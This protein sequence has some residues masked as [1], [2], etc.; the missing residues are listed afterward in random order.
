MDKVD[1]VTREILDW[2]KEQKDLPDDKKLLS[3][4]IAFMFAE[5]AANT[6]QLE[7]ITEV[8]RNVLKGLKT[9]E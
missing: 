5:A 2:L 9:D 6:E 1:E 8:K 3:I 4:K 7:K